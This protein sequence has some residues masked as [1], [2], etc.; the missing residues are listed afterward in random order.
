MSWTKRLPEPAKLVYNTLKESGP[1]TIRELTSKVKHPDVS[2]TK[3]KEVII[4][5][6]K[7]HQRI[8][9]KFIKGSESGKEKARDKWCFQ[10]THLPIETIPKPT[11]RRRFEEFLMEFVAM[12]PYKRG[13]I[14]CGSHKLPEIPRKDA[15]SEHM[16]HAV[17]VN[18]AR[19]ARNGESLKSLKLKTKALHSKIHRE[20]LRKFQIRKGIIPKSSKSPKLDLSVKKLLPKKLVKP[21]KPKQNPAARKSLKN[22]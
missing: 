9:T 14:L 10:A 20:R 2:I 19:S 21:K 22:K 5:Y 4:P 11:P 18:E 7:H 15:M 12:A 13:H 6:L 3:L 1:L 8:S 17:R 16:R